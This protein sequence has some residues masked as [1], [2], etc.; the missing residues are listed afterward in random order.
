[1]ASKKAACARKIFYV[2]ISL[3]TENLDLCVNKEP[4]PHVPMHSYGYFVV[5]SD[6]EQLMEKSQKRPKKAIKSQKKPD[7]FENLAFF[8]KNFGQ[9][10]A[11]KS[12]TYWKVRPKKAKKARSD[13]HFE[14]G[15]GFFWG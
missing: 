6:P 4:I 11:K 7:F 10:K 13:G 9:I 3:I 14:G 5:S 12:Q 8:P 15:S 1:M 2:Q